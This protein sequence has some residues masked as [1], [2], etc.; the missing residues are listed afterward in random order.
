MIRVIS[1]HLVCHVP[2]IIHRHVNSLLKQSTIFHIYRE[3]IIKKYTLPKL[4]KFITRIVERTKNVLAYIM[5]GFFL[6][7]DVYM[8]DERH[9]AA[10]YIQLWDYRMDKHGYN[11]GLLWFF[12]TLMYHPLGLPLTNQRRN[13]TLFLR[14][15][16]LNSNVQGVSLRDI[17]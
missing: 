11:S 8:I 10:A 7:L 5:V 16:I 4:I 9:D 14:R 1:A 3:I 2:K 6:T 13:L 12:P 15:S 17:E